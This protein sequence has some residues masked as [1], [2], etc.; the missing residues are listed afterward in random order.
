MCGS[1]SDKEVGGVGRGEGNTVHHNSC[2]PR[3]TQQVVTSEN[4]HMQTCT[5]NYPIK[6]VVTVSFLFKTH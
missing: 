4:I 5:I 1:L 3:L 6:L 2:I